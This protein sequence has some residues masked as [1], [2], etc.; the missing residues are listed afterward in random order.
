[1]MVFVD[2]SG[3]YALLDAGN[4]DYPAALEAWT[5]M[6]NREDMLVTSNYVVVET[7]ALLHRRFGIPAVRRFLGD[8]LSI[9][10][11]EWVDVS[12]HTMGINAVLAS[13]KSGPSLVDCVSF[14]TMRQ[15][16]IRTAFTFDNHF[17]EQGFECRP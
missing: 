10:M 3:V 11:I 1:M 6:V 17:R 12:M 13:S 2:T 7:C 8:V 14:A 16:G 4:V 9:I 15:Y 5:Q